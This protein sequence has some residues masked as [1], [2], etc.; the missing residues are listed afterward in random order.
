MELL[1]RPDDTTRAVQFC[2]IS[3]LSLQ[4]PK[5]ECHLSNGFLGALEFTAFATCSSTFSALPGLFCRLT[6]AVI[7]L[8]LR[9]FSVGC[10]NSH[11]SA[12]QAARTLHYNHCGANGSKIH[13]NHRK[14]GTDESVSDGAEIPSGR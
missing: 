14:C 2:Q 13:G 3:Q 9:V 4:L 11:F 12:L 8:G 5:Q 10:S 6:C 7:R 1:Q